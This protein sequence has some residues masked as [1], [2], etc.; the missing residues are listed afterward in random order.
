[1]WEAIEEVGRR[2]K[3]TIHEICTTVDRHRG[4]SSLTAA[5]RV[6]IVAYFR[7]AATEDGHARAGHGRTPSAVLAASAG[8]SGYA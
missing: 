7:A 3:Q 8:L 5:L 2:E 6:F 1:M 4:A